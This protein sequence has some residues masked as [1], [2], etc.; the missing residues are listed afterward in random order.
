MLIISLKREKNLLTQYVLGEITATSHI[1]DVEPDNSHIREL[2]DKRLCYFPAAVFQ[3]EKC[4]HR[5]EHPDAAWALRR[6]RKALSKAKLS[7]SI[8]PRSHCPFE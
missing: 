6:N 2:F 3:L 7:G 5:C 1:S 8:S 4:P